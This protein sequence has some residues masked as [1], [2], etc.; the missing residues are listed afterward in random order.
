MIHHRIL[1]RNR[2]RW[3]R[4]EDFTVAARAEFTLGEFD[5]YRG[6]HNISGLWIRYPP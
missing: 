5:K 2:D 6:P 4:E 1:E 3:E